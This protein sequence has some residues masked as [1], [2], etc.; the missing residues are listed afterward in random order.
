VAAAVGLSDRGLAPEKRGDI[1][2]DADEAYALVD[3]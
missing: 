2:G 3:G 1:Y